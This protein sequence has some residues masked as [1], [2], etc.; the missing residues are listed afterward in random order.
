M[1]H[2]V[3]FLFALQICTVFVAGCAVD[4]DDVDDA[5]LDA[6]S[7]VAEPGDAEPVATPDVPEAA[8]DGATDSIAAKALCTRIRLNNRATLNT[9]RNVCS[10]RGQTALGFD[11]QT[12]ICR[13]CSPGPL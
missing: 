4:D 9:C 11:N 10:G 13:C 2:L 6:S 3:R 5:E 8:P 7:D 1:S 12:K